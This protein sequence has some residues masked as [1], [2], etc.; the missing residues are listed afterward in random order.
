MTDAARPTSAPPAGT[1][2]RAEAGDR[3]ARAGTAR[4][5]RGVRREAGPGFYVVLLM[6]VIMAVG[7]IFLMV[8][9]SFKQQIDIVSGGTLLFAPTLDNYETVLCDLLWYEPEH[10]RFCDP[11]F[12]RALGNSLV[13][14][15]IS[16]VLTL[17]LFIV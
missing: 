4:G 17:I 13:I 8:T 16:T 2:V 10:L 7:P 14:A 5:R 9:T 12:S 15:T 3:A 11:T 1:P 6:L